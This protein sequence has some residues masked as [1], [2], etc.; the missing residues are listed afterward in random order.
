MGVALGSN[1]RHYS[2]AVDTNSGDHI[3]LEDEKIKE[4]RNIKETYKIHSPF[5]FSFVPANSIGFND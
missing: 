1:S 2:H 3:I 5:G 4:D